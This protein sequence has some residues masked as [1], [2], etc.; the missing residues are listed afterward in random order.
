MDKNGRWSAKFIGT[1]DLKRDDNAG[2]V[3]LNDA[4]VEVTTDIAQDRD[5]II[6]FSKMHQTA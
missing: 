4:G 1:Y 3:N 6:G 2:Q 5:K